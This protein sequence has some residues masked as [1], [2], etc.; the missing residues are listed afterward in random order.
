MRYRMVKR[1]RAPSIA[2]IL[3]III[4]AVTAVGAF[5]APPDPFVGRWESTDIDGS[6]QVMTI[7]GGPHRI[8]Y[9][10][11]G[12]T[13]CGLDPVTGDFLYGATARGSGTVSG[14]DYSG[15]WDVWCL[16]HPTTLIFTGL[17]FQF[18]YNAAS[19]TLTDLAGVVWNRR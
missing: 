14:T 11:F 12:A 13:V 19:D 2:A 4:V 9:H 6:Y 1:F 5:A 10:D 18:T 3:T 16:S 7:G 17:G 15:A 8:S